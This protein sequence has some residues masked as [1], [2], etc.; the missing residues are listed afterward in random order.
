MLHSIGEGFR[1]YVAI[2]LAPVCVFALLSGVSLSNDGILFLYL[3]FFFFQLVV[4][5]FILFREVYSTG[6]Y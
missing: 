3:L 4:F 5:Y 1:T 6:G 2:F